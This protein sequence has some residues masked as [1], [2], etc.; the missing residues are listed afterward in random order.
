VAPDPA[1]PDPGSIIAAATRLVPV[2][3]VPEIRLRCAAEPIGLWQRTEDELGQPGLPPP[4]WA[5][6]WAGGQALARYLLDH[7][8]VVA[9][10][11]VIDLASGS[12]LVAIAAAL[13]GAA[14]VTAYDVDP[15]AIAA[16]ELNA[17]ANG[18]RVTARCEDL[19]D[20]V[21]SPATDP[22]TG[23]GGALVPRPGAGSGDGLGAGP[24]G[25]PVSR[26]VTGP[27][28][29]PLPAADLVLVADAFYQR[30]LAARVLSFLDRARA[31]GAEV[32][33]ADL[34][35]AYLPRPR[36]SAITSYDVPGLAVVEDQDVRV[37]TIWALR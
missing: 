10:K 23:S 18:V 14:A 12:G 37:T 13:A 8:G 30:E 36:L 5:F 24:A 22:G 28:G 4:Y 26:P 17:A 31:A 20:P 7:P 3:L 35:R 6:A 29:A 19:L 9:G 15:L 21:G 2:P 11:Q 32:L 33:A 1:E 27:V 34:G 16:I 25:A